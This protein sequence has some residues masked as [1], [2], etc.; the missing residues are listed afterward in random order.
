M[1]K[2]FHDT[3]YRR[4]KQILREFATIVVFWIQAMA[5]LASNVVIWGSSVTLNPAVVYKS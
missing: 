5:Q 3:R 1:F 4:N 2:C